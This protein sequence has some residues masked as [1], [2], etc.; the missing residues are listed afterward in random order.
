MDKNNSS[1]ETALNHSIQITDRKTTLI[2]GVKKLEN[3]DS[4]EFFVE[5]VMGY[6]II[7]GENLELLKLDTYQ[8]TL[9]L[10][11]KLFFLSYVEENGKKSKG[12]S[13]MAKLFK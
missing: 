8:G 5:S 2:T 10:K 11:G 6:I 1:V 7:K 12:E 9:S 13:I 3:F 4:K